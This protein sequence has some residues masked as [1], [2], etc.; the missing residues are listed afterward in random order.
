MNR[1]NKITSKFSG[2]VVFISLYKNNIRLLELSQYDLE[3]PRFDVISFK[4]KGVYLTYCKEIV[5]N[6]LKNGGV[7]GYEYSEVK[8]FDGVSKYTPQTLEETADGRIKVILDKFKENGII[9]G[10][11]RVDGFKDTEIKIETY[12]KDDKIKYA[13]INI[14]YD[15]KKDDKIL[16]IKVMTSVMSGQLTKPKGYMTADNDYLRTLNQTH[17]RRDLK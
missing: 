15:I 17:I 8:E 13:T 2:D 1:V 16:R 5:I 12:Y 3:L 14:T 10:Y 9:T 11:D 6:L 4:N 7:E